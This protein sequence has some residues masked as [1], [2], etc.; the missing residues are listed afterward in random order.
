MALPKSA[1][2]VARIHRQQETE[3]SSDDMVMPEDQLLFVVGAQDH[4]ALL[5]AFE[6]E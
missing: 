5:K 1:K 2:G 6:A 3:L 4:D